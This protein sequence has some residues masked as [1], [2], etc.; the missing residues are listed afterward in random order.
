[1]QGAASTGFVVGVGDLITVF[2]AMISVGG[3][4]VAAR[5]AGATAKLLAAERSREEKRHFCLHLQQ[6]FD[7]P[8]FFRCRFKAWQQLNHGDFDSPVKLSELLRGDHWTPELST[9][10]HFFESLNRYCR[11]GLIDEPLATKL[12]GR[13]YEMWWNGL[14]SR[15]EVDE[16]GLPYQQWLEEVKGLH[17]RIVRVHAPAPPPT[18]KRWI[19]VP[20]LPLSGID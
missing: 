19:R 1:M 20:G 18:A 4:I 12:F 17:A 7:S 13:S 6:Q 5:I 14:I 15:I 8:E 3:A 2:A 16:A 10:F 9:T 11:E